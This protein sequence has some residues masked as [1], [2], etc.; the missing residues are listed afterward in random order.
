MDRTNREKLMVAPLALWLANKL[1]QRPA[2]KKVMRRADVK[3]EHQAKRLLSALRKRGDNMRKNSRW[4]AA[5]AGSIAV[6]IALLT[7]ASKR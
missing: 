7:R 6:G 5:G 1:L 4:L 3:V 2:A